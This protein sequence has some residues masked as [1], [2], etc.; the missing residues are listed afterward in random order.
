MRLQLLGC[1]NPQ[2]LSDGYRGKAGW[3]SQDKYARLANVEKV[4]GGTEKVALAEMRVAENAQ[5]ALLVFAFIQ[6]W[7]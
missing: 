3:E 7:Q 4:A 1:H 5:N 2:M 6:H